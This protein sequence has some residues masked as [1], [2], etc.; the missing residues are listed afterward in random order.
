MM[1]AVIAALFLAFVAGFIFRFVGF[2]LSWAGGLA[3]Y[4]TL[5]IP[6]DLSIGQSIV[7]VAVVGVAAQIGLVFSV[8]LQARMR[9]YGLLR[10]WSLIS[11]NCAR[12][13]R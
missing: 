2:A 3:L 1:S 12:P 13:F 5:L 11:A 7:S 6:A 9:Q 8:I 4:A 10:C